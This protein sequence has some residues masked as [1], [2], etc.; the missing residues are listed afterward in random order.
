MSDRIRKVN[1][2]IKH[3]VAEAL[4]RE[5]VGGFVTVKAVETTRDMKHADVWVSIIGENEE[6]TL[7]EIEEKRREVQQAVSAKLTSRNVPAIKFRLDHSGAYAQKI[8]EL[9]KNGSSES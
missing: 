3:E 5:G 9:L 7:T 8:E 6:E 2:L 4:K 1:E